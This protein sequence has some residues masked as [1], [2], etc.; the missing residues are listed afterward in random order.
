MKISSTFPTQEGA[1]GIA[2]AAHDGSGAFPDPLFSGAGDPGQRPGSGFS[3]FLS[4]GRYGGGG[5]LWEMLPYLKQAKPTPLQ[6]RRRCQAR[7]P[8]WAGT[9]SRQCV[10]RRAQRAAPSCPKHALSADGGWFI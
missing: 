10:D 7:E 1:P 6:P 4:F 3:S 5:K 2:A 8:L 9:R